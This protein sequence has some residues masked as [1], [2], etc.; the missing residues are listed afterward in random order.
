MKIS[1]DNT[2]LFLFAGLALGILFPEQAKSIS[3]LITGILIVMM[4]LS[5]RA[6]QFRDLKIGRNAK[7]VLISV[8]ISYVFLT[9]LL[10]IMGLFFS[11]NPDYFKGFFIVAL[12]PPAVV[13]I[14]YNMLLKGNN[15][16]ALIAE[17]LSYLLS[18]IIIPVG[19]FLVFGKSVDMFY[20]LQMVFLLVA[21]PLILSRF[22][23]FECSVFKYCKSAIN[24]CMLL[25]F[26]ILIGINQHT[27]LTG[28]VVIFG[29]LL[30]GII[31]TYLPPLLVFLGMKCPPHEKSTRMT[32]ALFS[33][34]K[35]LGTAA[36][37]ALAIFGETAALVPAI[38]VIA[39]APIYFF[40][41]N[42]VK[43]ESFKC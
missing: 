31:K 34:V 5:L 21:L 35:N 9:G 37:I 16:V 27:I 32:Y 41:E 20:L 23:R 3:F 33:S 19:I 8:L 29:I 17:V 38:I 36:V 42:I 39:E 22:L 43:V 40:F 15:E 30:A 10:L 12:M 14:A 26:F 28:T 6:V 24:I 4:T 2:S 25:L 13:V 11:G 18:L 1:F 7:P